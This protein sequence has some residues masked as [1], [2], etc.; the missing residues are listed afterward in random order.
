MIPALNMH[1]ENVRVVLRNEVNDITVCRDNRDSSHPF[2]TMI[3]VKSDA[4]R[5]FLTEQMNQGNLFSHAKNFVGSFSVGKELKL[6][7]HYESENLLQTVGSIYLYDFV[8]CKTAAMNLVGAMAEAGIDGPICRL[9]LNSRNINVNSDCSVT[10]NYFL[11]FN[12]FDPEEENFST[13]DC[14][15][16]Q[17]FK[18]LELPWKEKYHGDI[19]SYPDELRLFWMKMQ[20]HSFLTFGQIMAMLRSMPERPIARQG[21]IWRMKRTLKSIKNVLFRNPSRIV[22]TLLVVITVI[23]AA[24]QINMRIRLKQ[25]Y[26]S[27]ISYSAM[28]YIGTVYLGNEE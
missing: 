4:H 25:A 19:N 22:L 12:D 21:I 26:D 7:F 27:N 16:Q 2:Y 17:V 5:K 10:L 15:A 18:I 20:N 24:W 14:L 13:M 28:E 6:L 1:L 23:Y 3:S 9:M 8:K 11:D